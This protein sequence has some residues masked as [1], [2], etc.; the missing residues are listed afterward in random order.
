[1]ILPCVSPSVAT[2]QLSE[3]STKRSESVLDQLDLVLD[4]S[5]VRDVGVEGVNLG[6]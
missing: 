2:I 3:F 5:H 1:M 6:P 4:L